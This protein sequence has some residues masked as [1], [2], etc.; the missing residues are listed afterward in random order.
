VDQ[1]VVGSERD[2]EMKNR[3]PVGVGLDRS[4]AV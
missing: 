3:A 2:G 4:P 1:A